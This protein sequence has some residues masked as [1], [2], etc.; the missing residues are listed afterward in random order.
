MSV[1][2]KTKMKYVSAEVV[3]FDTK[4]PHHRSGLVM[5]KPT[6]IDYNN[7]MRRAWSRGSSHR[8]MTKVEKLEWRN[9]S[10]NSTGSG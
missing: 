8:A 2:S 3:K 1:D 6:A 7:V 10:K 9:P 4:I 5:V